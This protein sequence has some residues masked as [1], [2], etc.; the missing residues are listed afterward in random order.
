MVCGNFEGTEGWLAQ[1]LYAAVAS[2][3]AVKIFFTLVAIYS[4]MSTQADVITAFF[5]TV[6]PKGIHVY[7]RQ[8]T[9]FTNGTAK[10]CKLNKALYSLRRSPIWWY[11][12][13]TSY[14]K[15]LGFEL[16]LADQCLFQHRE[17]GILL[18]L[19]VN[20]FR[21]AAFIQTDMNWALA[22]LNNG[23]EL[24]VLEEDASFLGFEIRRNF[25]I[26]QIWLGQPFYAQKLIKKFGYEG[27]SPA[28]T[29]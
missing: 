16:M 22:K 23:F 20:D 3:I 8:P 19:Y 26:H 7:V 27:M 2:A 11:R 21:V 17:K 14:F 6:I 25:E 24:K 29:P 18:L 5:N 9:G 10:V 12:T 4:M 15:L 13:L 1:D 28:I